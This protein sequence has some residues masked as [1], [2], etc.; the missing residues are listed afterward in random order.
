[1]GNEWIVLNRENVAE[2]EKQL[3]KISKVN[4]EIRTNN[5]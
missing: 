4:L 5:V 1:M 3:A 2:M